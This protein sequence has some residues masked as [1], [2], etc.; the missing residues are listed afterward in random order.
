MMYWDT[1]IENLVDAV[2]ENDLVTIRDLLQ[3]GV[4]PNGCVDE[5]CLRPLHFAA[6]NNGVEAAKLLL[7]AGA[8]IYTRTEPDHDTPYDI[9][10]LF[11]HTAM[12]DLLMRYAQ[13]TGERH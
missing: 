13:P 12:M 6:Q 8:D 7:A 2:I 1:S 4:D 3:K 10:K 9:A 11:K 5:A